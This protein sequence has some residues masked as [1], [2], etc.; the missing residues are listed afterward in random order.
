MSNELT[1]KKS[2][3]NSLSTVTLIIAL[4]SLLVSGFLFM[5]SKNTTGTTKQQA[6]TS[7]E[8]IKRTGVL[9]VGYGGFPPYTIVDLNEKDPN[10]KVKG[11]C[12]DMVNEIASKCTPA[13]KVEWY[14]LS[15]E[16]FN[17]DMNS[18]KF[19]FL[20]DGTYATI[21]KAYD[22]DFTTPF[23]YFG[24]CVAVVK[25]DDNRFKNFQDLNRSDITISYAQGYV[26]GDFAMAHL[27]KPKFKST[28]V[29]KDAFSQLDD[30]IMGRADVAVQDVPTVVQYVKNHSD[31]VKALWIDNPPSSVAGCFVTRKG[32]QELLNFL[33][34]SIT[35]MQVDGTLDKI[36]AKWNS[37]GHFQK[38]NLYPGHG[39]K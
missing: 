26:S 36:D 6:E 28:V 29:G 15:W 39:L 13:L 19:D 24:L 31:K 3:S 37:L 38:L 4:I 34:A 12:I 9:R 20:A 33:N 1:H 5:K 23:S 25:K 18:G 21:P 7:M 2:N 17:A 10:K 14:N 22:F 11:F 35:I 30:V 27:D 32:D 16:N 8:R